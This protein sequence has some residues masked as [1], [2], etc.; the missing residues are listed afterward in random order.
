MRS[1]SVACKV[2][3]DIYK[4]LVDKMLKSLD[5]REKSLDK[6]EKSFDKPQNCFDKPLIPA[7]KPHSH[8]SVTLYFR[9]VSRIVECRCLLLCI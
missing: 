1:D 5:K 3:V 2:D 7:K 4:K 9:L 6:Q 8:R